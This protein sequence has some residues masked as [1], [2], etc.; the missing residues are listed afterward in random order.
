MLSKLERE[1]KKELRKRK[2]EEK[3]TSEVKDMEYI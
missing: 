2:M 3:T 1:R